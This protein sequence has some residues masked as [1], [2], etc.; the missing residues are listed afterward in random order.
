[1]VYDFILLTVLAAIIDQVKTLSALRYGSD[2]DVNDIK[3][4]YRRGDALSYLTLDN[5]F[6]YI[7]S[8]FAICL[9]QMSVSI[10]TSDSNKC[11]LSA[12]QS[13]F[14]CLHYYVASGTTSYYYFEL[15]DDYT[16]TSNLQTYTPS[17]VISGSSYGSISISLK[18]TLANGTSVNYLSSS[19]SIYRL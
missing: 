14:W 7:N 3:I 15:S 19:E 16:V 9:Q 18:G 6:D 2:S 5:S 11:T 10:S 1:M 17:T 12:A 13:G 8:G 4:E